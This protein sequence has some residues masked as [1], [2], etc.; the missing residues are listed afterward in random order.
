MSPRGIHACST[1][2]MKVQPLE[3][4]MEIEQVAPLYSG[5]AVA[6]KVVGLC[7]HDEP[8]DAYTHVS[9]I[10]QH[11]NRRHCKMAP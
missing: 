8:Q 4:K 9:F 6:I 7:V 3:M 5:S 2:H 1:C 11:A 10:S